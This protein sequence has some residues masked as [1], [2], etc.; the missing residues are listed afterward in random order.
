MIGVT[1]P[2]GSHWELRHLCLDLN[3]T[4]ALDGVLL[5][6]VADTLRALGEDLEIH[7]LTA[8]TH[9]GIGEVE[10]QLGVKAVPIG[11]GPEKEAYV[12]QLGA[13]HCVAVG[14]GRNDAAMLQRARLGIAV[15]GPEGMSAVTA[16]AADIVV[17]DI[18]RGLE[19]LRHP[20]RIVATLRP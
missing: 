13:E 4:L 15:L 20:L 17:G 16:Q 12:A 5:P 6:G 7:L 11:R 8:G 19:L 10:R 9:G 14:N 3:G 2:D 1:W 18:L